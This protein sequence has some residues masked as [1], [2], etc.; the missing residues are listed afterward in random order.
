M[1]RWL[2]FTKETN[3]ARRRI[4]RRE[5]FRG[6][7]QTTPLDQSSSQSG[8]E[9]SQVKIARALI[10]GP[11]AVAKAA[12]IVDTDAQCKMVVLRE[13]N[14]GFTCMPGQPN[15][16]GEP[17][18]CADAA[19]MRSA[20]GRPLPDWP[21]L[22]QPSPGSCQPPT[23][24]PTAAVL[25]STGHSSFADGT[26]NH[27]P[28]IRPALAL[29]QVWWTDGGHRTTYRCS[30]PTPFST[31]VGH[32]CGMKL[33]LHNSKTL[34]GSPR[35][36]LVRSA[37]DPIPTSRPLFHR[38]RPSILVPTPSPTPSSPSVSTPAD[39]NTSPSLHS[40]CIR[41]ASAAPAASF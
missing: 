37:P 27:R 3:E 1:G 16:V 41:T 33:L 5:R 35:F 14:N 36:A 12:R 2:G 34:H 40:I 20:S 23:L 26:R 31:T 21:P 17:P 24:H 29:P 32:Y 28:G 9:S 25:R 38:F 19:S 6:A 22:L 30:N 39:F 4:R 7:A 18:M 8:G 10:A 11:A 15:L 13:G